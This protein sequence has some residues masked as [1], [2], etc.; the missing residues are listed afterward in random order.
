L[1]LIVVVCHFPQ[2]KLYHL[3]W[4]G[5]RHSF[6]KRTQGKVYHACMEFPN[7]ITL[8]TNAFGDFLCPLCEGIFTGNDVIHQLLEIS[9]LSF[10]L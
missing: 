8:S 4:I 9:I 10:K 7:I 3:T 1:F 2:L 5:G 6:I